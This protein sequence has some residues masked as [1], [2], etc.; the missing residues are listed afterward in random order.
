MDHI[1]PSM[2]DRTEQI[3]LPIRAEAASNIPTF[4]KHVRPKI[5]VCHRPAAPIP[6]V[7]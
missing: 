6:T 7:N 1:I 5:S 4:L 3:S 2:I